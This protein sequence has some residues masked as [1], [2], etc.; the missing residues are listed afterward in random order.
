MCQKQ[1]TKYKCGHF[2]DRPEFPNHIM[3][4]SKFHRTGTQCVPLELVSVPIRE[5]CGEC[6]WLRETDRFR[7]E[8]YSGRRGR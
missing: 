1:V 5:T 7:D 4:C 6:Q 3:Y 8:G 2:G